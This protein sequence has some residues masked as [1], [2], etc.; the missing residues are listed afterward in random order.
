MMGL[1]PADARITAITRGLSK[2]LT[3]CESLWG[4]FG[5]YR[6]H[7]RDSLTVFVAPATR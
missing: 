5:F 3:M 4:D 2:K 7:D 1:Q 6:H